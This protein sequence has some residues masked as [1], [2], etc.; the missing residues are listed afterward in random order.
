VRGS[1][2]NRTRNCA[3]YSTGQYGI[4]PR[5]RPGGGVAEFA[6]TDEKGLAVDHDLSGAVLY[7]NAALCVSVLR[8][9]RLSGVDHGPGQREAPAAR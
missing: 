3:I 5:R 7:A 1:A 9:D 4:R 8:W 6:S 2:R